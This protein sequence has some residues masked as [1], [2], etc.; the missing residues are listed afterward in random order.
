MA[1]NLA[2]RG[3]G[4]D[5]AALRGRQLR[6]AERQTGLGLR[7]VGPGQI[8]DLE[9][10]LSRLQIGVEHLYIVLVQLDDRAVADHVHVGR[11][12][13]R[14]DIAFDRSQGGPARLDPRFRCAD[15][16][17][18]RSAVE[19][20][21]GDVDTAARELML[22]ELPCVCA[23]TPLRVRFR[24]SPTWP[25]TCGRPAALAIATVASV[26]RSVL[27]GRSG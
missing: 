12:R 21:I 3:F 4:A 1:D 2:I 18:D 23:I 15:A 6:A 5:Q 24:L 14:E 20:G 7:D 9:P 10:V 8:A 17:F 27:A 25:L 19:Q 26:P 11:D 16:V 22:C 13:L